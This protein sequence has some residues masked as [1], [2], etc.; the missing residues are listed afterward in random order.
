MA[1]ALVV[2]AASLLFGCGGIEGQVAPVDEG[3]ETIDTGSQ[4][5][6][7]DAGPREAAVTPTAPDPTPEPLPP[8]LSCRED[9]IL[10][11]GGTYRH[12][13]DEDEQRPEIER[14][15]LPPPPLRTVELQPFCIDKYEYPNRAG[16]VPMVS[17]SWEKAKELCRRTGKRLCR[18]E[19]WEAACHGQERRSFA[20]GSRL[21]RSDCN[22]Y[23]DINKPPFVLPSGSFPN[24]RS[25]EGVFDLDGNVSEF[26]DAVYEGPMLD[27][28]E[29]QEVVP[30]DVPRAMLRGGGPWPSAYGQSCFSRHWHPVSLTPWDDDGFRCCSD[31]VRSPAGE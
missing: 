26:V 27:L 12:G 8:G 1:R 10:L 16:E 31:P 9:M 28:P 5:K 13:W 15:A 11:P 23:S 24:C 21:L 25:P 29:A 22:I 3:P 19:E 30:P 7:I 17:V 14:S 20:I 6:P 2:A 18:E 4:E